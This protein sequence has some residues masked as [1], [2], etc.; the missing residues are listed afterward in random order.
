[1]IDLIDRKISKLFLI[2]DRF[3]IK[4]L[5]SRDEINGF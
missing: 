3:T 5:Q 2:L 4:K 1:M